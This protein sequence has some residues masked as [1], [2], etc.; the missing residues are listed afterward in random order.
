[1]GIHVYFHPNSGYI[2]KNLRISCSI[3]I[4][5]AKPVQWINRK[6]PPMRKPTSHLPVQSSDSRR[7]QAQKPLL[8]ADGQLLSRQA[9]A[10]ARVQSVPTRDK[11]QP[12]YTSTTKAR[13]WRGH[14]CW[15]PPCPLKLG[16]FYHA[17]LLDPTGSP[18][19][20]PGSLEAT[21]S[22]GGDPNQNEN[23]KKERSWWE[24]WC[25]D[26][27]CDFSLS[28]LKELICQLNM[29]HSVGQLRCS[30][31]SNIHGHG[32][33]SQIISTDLL[34]GMGIIWIQYLH[35]RANGCLLLLP[36][37]LHRL[38]LLG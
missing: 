29:K 6:S 26:W 23:G 9:Q 21:G 22:P 1:M 36:Y 19:S 35:S 25:A 13:P 5:K 28:V 31:P 2:Q 37:L 16:E 24:P 15:V 7:T 33:Q 14:A 4:K 38:S 27:N 12:Q 34:K 17:P 18:G 20:S 8:Q 30:L 32:I 11:N 3:A 10:Q